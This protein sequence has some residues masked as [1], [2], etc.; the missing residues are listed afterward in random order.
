MAR[1]PLLARPSSQGRRVALGCGFS[2]LVK[3]VTMG[4]AKKK[5]GDIHQ[6]KYDTEV[7][8][9]GMNF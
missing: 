6:L 1:T 3:K 8:A 9:T 2:S 5:K 7:S 4:E